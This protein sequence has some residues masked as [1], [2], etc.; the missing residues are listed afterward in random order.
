[1]AQ[2]LF[3][4]DAATTVASGG[5]DAPAGGTGESW[6]VTSS[7]SFPAASSTANPPSQFHVADPAAPSE[8]IAVTNVASTTWTV[9]RGAESTIPV[10]HSAG[11]TVVQVV[12]AGDYTAMYP[13][14]PTSV[15]SGTVT[16]SVGQMVLIST[17]GSAGTINLPHAPAGVAPAVGAK[18]VTYGTA[19][20]VTVN[21]IGGDTFSSGGSTATLTVLG[22]GAIWQYDAA[23][24]EW[25]KQANDLPLGQLDSRYVF[26]NLTQTASTLPVFSITPN[27]T[28]TPS[29][30]TSL[31]TTGTFGSGPSV[32]ESIYNEGY[33]VPGSTGY[34]SSDYSGYWSVLPNCGDSVALQ[35]QWNV[36]F[37]DG[38]AF[39]PV[40][41]YASRSGSKA[42]RTFIDMSG[43]GGQF[44]VAAAGVTQFSV[45]GGAVN[46][47][48]PLYAGAQF[49]HQGTTLGFYNTTPVGQQAQAGVTAGFTGGTSTTVTVDST[50]TGG[51]GSHPYTIG[52]I[53]HILRTLGLMT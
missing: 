14:I 1:M 28:A 50:F 41:T 40:K 36:T 24:T 11:F 27:Q 6:T 46:V 13:L 8:V 12:T 5:T 43:T 53:V 35:M 29:P 2:E 25:V 4:N 42:L 23:L 32:T 10:T 15:Q 37:P 49:R 30:F 45:A 31:V 3:A 33:N 52:D 34:N 47:D 44:V 51:S 17:A 16:A 38:S 20:T 48:I 7:A 19:N 9:T 21:A 39:Q 26:Q 22:E 18:L